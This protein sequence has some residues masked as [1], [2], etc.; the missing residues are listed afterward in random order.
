MVIRLAALLASIF[1]LGCVSSAEDSE[2]A[3][4]VGKYLSATNVVPLD[5]SEAYRTH[6]GKIV[7]VGPGTNGAPH[8]TYYEVTSAD[9]IQKLTHA[10][11]EA[12]SKVYGAKKITLHFM[13]K[14]VFRQSPN[15]SGLR[16][17]EKE[18]ATVVIRKH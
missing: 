10:A 6:R 1:L 3:S 8:F 11:E 14:E 12:V 5:S 4:E 9:D 2:I 13:E 18:V 16:G 17:S 15:G 7:Y